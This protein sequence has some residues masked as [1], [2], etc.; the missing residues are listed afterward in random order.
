MCCYHILHKNS[1]NW[2]L[3]EDLTG[4]PPP[5][6]KKVSELKWAIIYNILCTFS[7]S[8]CC[9]CRTLTKIRPK[10][11]DF[12]RYSYSVGKRA[13]QIAVFSYQKVTDS[14]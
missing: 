10:N 14:I 13:V 11:I 4:F 12:Y 3:I 1:I 6:K 5:P 7:R 9:V 2:S 8:I